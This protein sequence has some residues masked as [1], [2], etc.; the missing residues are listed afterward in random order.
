[1]GE[2]ARRIQEFKQK[3]GINNL[4]DER[5]VEWK[6]LNQAEGSALGV[7]TTNADFSWNKFGGGSWGQPPSRGK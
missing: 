1:V 6:Y 7:S 2:K 3:Y 5:E 4:R